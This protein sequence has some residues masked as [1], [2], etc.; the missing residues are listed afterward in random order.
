MQKQNSS[1]VCR[2]FAD[3]PTP[4]PE[5]QGCRIGKQYPRGTQPELN[6]MDKHLRS[7]EGNVGVL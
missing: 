2:M 3:Q 7:G 6:E 5:K 1:F 4:Q